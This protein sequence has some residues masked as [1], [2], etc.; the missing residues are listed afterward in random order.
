MAVAKVKVEGAKE[1]EKEIRGVQNALNK[2]N[3]T[4]S[5]N[6][7]ATRLL[8]RATGGAIT[9]FQD[10]QKGVTQGITTVEG[11]SKSFKGLRVA[12]AATGIGLIVVALGTIATYWDRS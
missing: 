4:V 3:E 6:R 10:F 12:I 5:K 2:F 1:A 11:L 8:D 9:K 7:D